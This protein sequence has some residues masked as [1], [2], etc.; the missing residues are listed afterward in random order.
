MDLLAKVRLGED[1]VAD[2]REARAEAG[3]TFGKPILA[4]Y[5]AAKRATLRPG[6]FAEVERHLTGHAAPLHNR[7]LANID[8]KMVA[9]LLSKIAADA[10]IPTSNR[11]RSSIGAYY[12][13]LMMEGLADASPI[14]DI[15]KRPEGDGRARVLAIPE[16]V[17]ILQ[18]TADGTDHGDII[19]LL[20][21]AGARKSEI[22]DLAR[23]EI[24]FDAGVIN[25]P[26]MRMK[27]ARAHAIPITL[28]MRT[29]LQRRA[30]RPGALFGRTGERRI[31]RM[32]AQQ[33]PA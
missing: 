16:L 24:D 2:K 4:R 15:A 3:A 32:V 7:R 28:P 33:G 13:W 19:W 26:G 9:G 31:Q 29:I 30:D 17:A 22:G 10:G 11:V 5:L 1:P 27:G 18:A 23:G 6:S 8:R 14:T 25:I 21:L 20:T 12:V